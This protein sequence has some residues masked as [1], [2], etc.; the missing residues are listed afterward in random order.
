MSNDNSTRLRSA[1]DRYRS[2]CEQH[3]EDAIL[4]ASNPHLV[5]V[6]IDAVVSQDKLIAELIERALN[7]GPSAIIGR[8]IA[9]IIKHECSEWMKAGAY[10]WK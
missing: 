6:V 1:I 5:D 10:K 2:T 8:D 4:H 7:D 3:A 9:D